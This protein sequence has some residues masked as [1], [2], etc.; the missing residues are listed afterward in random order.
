[1]SFHGDIFVFSLKMGASVLPSGALS[2]QSHHREGQ[3]WDPGVSLGGL[4]K[5]LNGCGPRFPQ[6]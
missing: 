6:M 5:G 1:M 2:C 4:D 3:D